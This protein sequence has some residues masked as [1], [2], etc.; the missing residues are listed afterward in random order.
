MKITRDIYRFLQVRFSDK[1]MKT[2]DLV[3]GVSHL[4]R[5][6]F[7]D[8]LAGLMADH[9]DLTEGLEQ[10]HITNWKIWHT[11]RLPSRRI[12]VNPLIKSP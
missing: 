8:D 10:V 1:P 5:S 9:Y 12:S 7:F 4:I 3:F 2:E 6:G 11:K